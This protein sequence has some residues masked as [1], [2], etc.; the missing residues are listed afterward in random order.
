MDNLL[1]NE[2]TLCL[3]VENDRIRELL[4]CVALHPRDIIDRAQDEGCESCGGRRR[5]AKIG[6]Q[7]QLAAIV[8]HISKCLVREGVD[9]VKKILGVKRLVVYVDGQRQVL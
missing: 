2:D 4:P 1:L 3:L 7:K 8:Q 6:R 5:E 9:E